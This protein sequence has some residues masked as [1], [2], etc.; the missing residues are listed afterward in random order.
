M[1]SP[2]LEI[3]GLG[4]AGQFSWFPT[5]IHFTHNNSLIEIYDP[6]YKV[7]LF[8]TYYIMHFWKLP[9]WTA[10]LVVFFVVVIKIS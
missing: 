5:E 6:Y 4:K 2:P 10:V 3:L 9:T 8:K 1:L 7:Q